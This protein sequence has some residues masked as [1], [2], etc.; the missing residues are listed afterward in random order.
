M[1]G[2]PPQPALRGDAAEFK[3][4]GGDILA[5]Q[6]I[7]A[8]NGG[9]QAPVLELERKGTSVHLVG[10]VQQFALGANPLHPFLELPEVGGF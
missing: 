6:T 7:P 5:H 1:K 4:V 9:R 3:R 2:R 8:R 10:G